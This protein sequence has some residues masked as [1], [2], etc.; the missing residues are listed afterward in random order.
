MCA[1]NP[2]TDANGDWVIPFWGPWLDPNHPKKA[3]P[4]ELRWCVADPDGNDFWVD[5][6]EP[7]LF[8]GTHKPVK[9]KSRT[10]IPG[11]LQDNPYLINT[12]YAATLD[13]LPEPLRSAMRD[14]NFMLSRKD[15]DMQVIPS[16][17]VRQAQARWK[18]EPPP[19]VPQSS[20]TADVAQGGDDENVIGW[21]HDWWFSKQ[22]II[23]GKATPLGTDVTGPLIVKR[24]DASEIAIDV[25]GGYGGSVYK[26]LKENR[27]KATGYNGA[28]KTNQKA[29]G[30]KL[31]FANWR[32]RDWW[33][34]REALDPSQPGG[35]K[36]A[37]PPCNQL[38]ADLTAPTYTVAARGIQIESKDQIKKR[39]G[40][41]PDRGDQVVM[42]WATGPKGTGTDAMYNG[43]SDPSSKHG[44]MVSGNRGNKP[45]VNLGYKNRRQ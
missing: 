21:R 23:P 26:T 34:L 4:G 38:A 25:G 39:L 42:C 45:K 1:S 7:Y 20:I 36:I 31:K 12:E 5:G 3:A 14:G 32:A 35:S 27:I 2:P 24:Q 43:D 40:R 8:P 16:D 19:N 29:V 17:W 15:A 41:S 10:F 6:P 22:E 9:P 33:R 11:R 13:A 44:V 28:K 30:S 18:P 37:I